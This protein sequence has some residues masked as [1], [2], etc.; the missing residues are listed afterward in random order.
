M[1]TWER[2]PES[3]FTNPLQ[4]LTVGVS[5]LRAFNKHADTGRF[6]C[7]GLFYEKNL[8]LSVSYE[9]SQNNIQNNRFQCVSL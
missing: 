8:H 2:C 5:K 9:Y 3:F 6:L 7:S 4:I 1:K